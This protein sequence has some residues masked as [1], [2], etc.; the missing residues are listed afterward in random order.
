M[1]YVLLIVGFFLIIKAS[2]VLIDA[3][4]SIALKFGVSKMLISL[5]IVAFGTCAPEI[6]ISFNSVSSGNGNMALANVVGSCIVNVFLIIG[7]AA[8]INPIQIKHVTIKKELPILVLITLGFFV[9]VSDSMFVPKIPDIL[10]R[11]D[12][13]I[14]MILFSLFILY[15]LKA[16]RSRNKNEAPPETKYGTGMSVILII[17]AIAVIAFSSDLIVNN[18][19]VIA[20]NFGISQKIITLCTIVIGT[21][22]PELVMTVSSAKKG[23]FDIAVGN[24]IGTNIFNICIVLGL[25]IAIFGGLEIVGFNFIDML[26]VLASSLVLYMFAR[27][28]RKITKIEGAF[29]V[30]CF[31]SYYAYA[32]MS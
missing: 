6:A 24:I 25:P 16:I 14:L 28:D 5:T 8:F 2:D 3:S 19:I 21:S 23:E 20:E 18:A 9:L 7:I 15:L 12:G 30:L 22:L 32:L 4:S 1:E 10:T 29:M 31:I 11:A 27:S 17:V 26:F 13:V